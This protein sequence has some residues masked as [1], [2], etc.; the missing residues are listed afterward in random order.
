MS[1]SSRH[2]LGGAHRQVRRAGVPCECKCKSNSEV[3]WV[4]GHHNTGGWSGD[5]F[6]GDGGA[7]GTGLAANSGV[8]SALAEATQ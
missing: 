4:E 6:L 1:A 7:S 5:F 2:V 8:F 3:E